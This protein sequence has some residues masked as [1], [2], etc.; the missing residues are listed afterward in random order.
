[1]PVFRWDGLTRIERLIRRSS[2]YADV[3]GVR[4]GER[5]RSQDDVLADLAEF[6]GMEKPPLRVDGNSRGD[7]LKTGVAIGRMEVYMRIMQIARTTPAQVQSY[8]EAALRP[9]KESEERD[10]DHVG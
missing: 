5:T 6:C 9:K 10:D 4:H 1:M 8:F 2:A 3:F 7:P